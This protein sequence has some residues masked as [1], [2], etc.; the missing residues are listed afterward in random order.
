MAENIYAEGVC[1]LC[2]TTLL[3][4]FEQEGTM[5]KKNLARENGTNAYTIIPPL[6]FQN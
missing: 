4:G 1:L 2:D 6:P 3:P 5:H